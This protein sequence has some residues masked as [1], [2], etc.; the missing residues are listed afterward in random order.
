MLHAILSHLA[1]D[2]DLAVVNRALDALWH[3]NKE[4]RAASECARVSITIKHSQI[5]DAIPHLRMWRSLRAV[6]ILS[7]LMETPLD[8]LSLI[9]NV[10]PHLTSLVLK[11]TNFHH[12][13]VA[14]I[15]KALLPWRHSLTHLELH[16]CDLVTS[17]G[18]CKDE[19]T[20]E[21]GD[22]FQEPDHMN[23][24]LWCLDLPLLTSLIITD[25]S[26]RCMLWLSSIW[27]LYSI[28][29][30]GCSILHDLELDDARLTAVEGLSNKRSLH[31]VSCA[32]NGELAVIDVSGCIQLESLVVNGLDK[33]AS[34]ILSG[35]NALRVLTLD[36]CPKLASVNLSD[37]ASLEALTCVRSKL[38]VSLDTTN[39]GKLE[40]VTCV[41]NPALDVMTLPR[42]INGGGSASGNADGSS[43]SDSTRGSSMSSSLKTLACSYNPRLG[44]LELAGLFGLE[45]LTIAYNDSLAELS[46]PGLH[47]LRTV[48]CNHNAALS[49]VQLA[50][51]VA[52]RELLCN[53]NKSLAVVEVS[54]CV[55]LSTITCLYNYHLSKLNLSDCISLRDL[56]TTGCLR[57]GNVNIATCV[58]LRSV[59]GHRFSQGMTVLRIRALDA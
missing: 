20:G 27:S 24:G 46:A 8:N 59:R 43:G 58:A 31:S 48:T 35:C 5:E 3:T 54:G 29:V 30:S 22:D 10:V 36:T 18:I 42:I 25:S 45:T 38:L 56:D 23:P 21:G 53:D 34:V 19:D 57:L 4:L 49:A 37:C 15:D 52:L 40:S 26:S 2:P 11:S 28:D 55:L 12:M 6:T 13:E 33:L 1:K 9:S 47:S 51:G 39:C 44:A 14:D 16:N 17:A 7:T 50:G 32:N 41:D